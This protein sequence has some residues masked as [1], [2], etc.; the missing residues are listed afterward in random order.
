MHCSSALPCVKSF[1]HPTTSQ[2]LP[3][4]SRGPNVLCQLH[5]VGKPRGVGWHRVPR[6][7]PTSS[8]CGSG[9]VP[10]ATAPAAQVHGLALSR[11]LGSAMPQVD[12]KEQRT[13]V[14]NQQCW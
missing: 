3:E 13:G 12:S 9:P 14:Y 7:T 6:P 5:G 11:P 1:R 4:Q 8:P 2:A 10:P